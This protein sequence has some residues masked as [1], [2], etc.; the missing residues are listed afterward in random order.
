MRSTTFK[1]GVAIGRPHNNK[2]MHARSDSS[3]D[4]AKTDR[5]KAH[6]YSNC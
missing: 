1:P 4:K 2:D 6:T 5:A 3:P